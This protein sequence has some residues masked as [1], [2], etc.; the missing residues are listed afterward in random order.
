[1]DR[2]EQALDLAALGRGGRQTGEQVARGGGGLG[3]TAG[4][5]VSERQVEPRF[6]KVRFGVEREIGRASC[7]ERV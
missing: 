4:L 1:M 7:R 3:S 5:R 6:V 2:F